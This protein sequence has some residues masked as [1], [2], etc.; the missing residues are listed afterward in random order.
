MRAQACSQHAVHV[1]RNDTLDR[2]DVVDEEG[3]VIGHR[4]SQ[5]EAVQLAIHEAQHAHNQGHDVVVCVEQPDGH[6]ALA[7]SSP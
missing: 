3:R 1:D 7:W 4:P 2:W 6:Y 5:A